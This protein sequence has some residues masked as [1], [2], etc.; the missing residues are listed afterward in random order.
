MKP[1]S[2]YA[3]A[4]AIVIATVG[5]TAVA[6]PQHVFAAEPTCT[7]TP[8][9][10]PESLPLSNQFTV[11]NGANVSCTGQVQ[12]IQI[13]V[14][15]DMSDAGGPYQTVQQWGA[16]QHSN[17]PRAQFTMSYQQA[18]ASGEQASFRI[19]VIDYVTNPDGTVQS[20]ELVRTATATCDLTL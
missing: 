3:R 7:M 10:A 19:D 17:V 16:G 2:F 8:I 14:T 12:F 18:C 13:D 6:A 4:C 5:G 11:D 20:E 15:L 1:L 9:L